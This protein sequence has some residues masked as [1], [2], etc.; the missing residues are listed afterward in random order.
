MADKPVTWFKCRECRTEF[1]IKGTMKKDP[2][3]PWWYF[4]Y[5]HTDMAVSCPRCGR[6]RLTNLTE[7]D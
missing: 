4:K 2:A 1:A 6:H 3:H 5:K 7:K